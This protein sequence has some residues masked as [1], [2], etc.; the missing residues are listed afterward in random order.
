MEGMNPGNFPEVKAVMYLGRELQ[1]L[2]LDTT[3]KVWTQPTMQF[4]DTLLIEFG[5]FPLQT[6]QV[7]PF[8]GVEE[9]HQVKKFPNVVVQRCLNFT[10]VSCVEL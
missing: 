6:F 3:K 4:L 7:G 2:T 10:F 9:I 1:N 8:F 5:V